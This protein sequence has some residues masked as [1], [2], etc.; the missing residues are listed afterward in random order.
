MQIHNNLLEAAE[1][2]HII[3]PG[4]KSKYSNLAWKLEGVSE[5]TESTTTAIIP[6]TSSEHDHSDLPVSIEDLRR[7][8]INTF[9]SISTKSSNS[10]KELEE[11]EV[12]HLVRKYSPRLRLAMYAQQPSGANLHHDSR[13]L[14]R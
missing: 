3:P 10:R 14:I 5:P 12:N 8:G 9:E 1:I 13:K 7:H 11:Q 6:K 4:S 2:L